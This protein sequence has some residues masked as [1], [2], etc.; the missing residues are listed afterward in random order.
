LRNSKSPFRRSVRIPEQFQESRSGFSPY[1]T[2]VHWNNVFAMSHGAHSADVHITLN[3]P[4]L[5]LPVAQL[6][7]DF[8]ILREGV[9]HPPAEAEMVLW[10][11]D[12]ESRWT[13]FLPSGLRDDLVRIPIAPGK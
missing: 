5:S 2:A 7:P 10:V 1:G 12:S 8:I 4:N 11:D 9:N 6:G 13:V 3:L